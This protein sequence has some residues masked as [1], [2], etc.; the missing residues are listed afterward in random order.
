MQ[1]SIASRSAPARNRRVTSRIV[2]PPHPSRSSWPLFREALW[3]FADAGL[4]RQ[5]CDPKRQYFT[6]GLFLA[7]QGGEFAQ[8]QIEVFDGAFAIAQA[9]VEFAS[10]THSRKTQACIQGL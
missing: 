9:G 7:Q 4:R 5:G 1:H 6:G 3:A 10:V 8:A 2:R